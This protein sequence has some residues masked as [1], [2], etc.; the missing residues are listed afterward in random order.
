[1]IKKCKC[2]CGDSY[3]EDIEP[4]GEHNYEMIITQTADCTRE[5]IPAFGHEIGDWEIVI[6]PEWFNEGKQIKK[7][8]VCNEILEEE[9]I[10]QIYPNNALIISGVKITFP[11]FSASIW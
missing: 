4:T 8:I 2:I 5:D 1:M 7:C 11:L 9:I 6:Q 3:T 10:P